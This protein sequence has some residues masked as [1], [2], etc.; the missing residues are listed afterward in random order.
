MKRWPTQLL[1]KVLEVSRER[2]EPTEYPDTPFNYVGLESIEG[3]TG[4][5]LPYQ[6]TAGA[7]IKS[8]KN[9]F[10]RGEILYGKLRPYLNKVH[11]ADDDGICSTDIYVLRPRQGQIHPSFAAN[12]LRSPS[13]LSVISNAMAGA[14]LPRIGQN[15]LLNIPV[16][17]PR[18]VEQE[19]IV[20]LLGEADELR[21]LRA[22]AD[23]RTAEFIPAL[24]HE[25]FG[26]P[27]SN[28]K[29]WPIVP[30]GEL[31]I[32]CEYGCSQKANEDSEGVPMLRMG[33]VTSAGT[34]DLSD[35]KHVLFEKNELPK[36]R[37]ASGDVL[38]NRTNSR[39][40]VGKTGIWDGRFEAVA[41][42]YFIRLRFDPKREHPQH[43]TTFMNLTHMKQRLMEIAR[44]AIG[45]SNI[46]AQELKAIPVPVPPF[47]LQKKFAQR[48]TEIRELESGQA[49]S[50]RRLEELL[51]SLVH[52]AF[53]EEL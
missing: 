18:L 6:L 13:V 41:A 25:M 48:V 53:N 29:R 20:K 52:R 4:N 11:L 21:K 38:F 33:N 40:L 5:L 9:V 1:G 32:L 46:N 47:P 30:A 3:H 34:L 49:T 15:A 24:F 23:S 22:Q 37:L 31:M 8:T 14:N 42:S 51:Q 16:P 35:L 50:R 27:A 12:Y 45:Q 17:V 19:R 2:I 10:H 36:Y 39:E 26:D 44:G 28:S 7:K 43:F